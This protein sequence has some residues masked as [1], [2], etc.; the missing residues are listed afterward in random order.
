MRQHEFK[1]QMDRLS[2]LTVRHTT[3]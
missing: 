2:Y 1:V 3:A